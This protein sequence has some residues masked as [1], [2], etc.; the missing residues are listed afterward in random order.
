MM[1]LT[2]K[3]PRRPAGRQVKAT[4]AVPPPDLTPTEIAVLKALREMDDRA[5]VFIGK[6]A[7][8]QAERC[9]RRIAPS[10]QLIAGGRP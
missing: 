3:P 10:L 6:L 5:R 2:T 1:T 4:Q 7:A 8:A 9:P